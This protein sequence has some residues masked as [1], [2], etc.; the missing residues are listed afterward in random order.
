MSG[1]ILYTAG[2]ARSQKVQVHKPEASA[3]TSQCIC[4]TCQGVHS[5]L[6][7]LQQPA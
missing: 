2:C 7:M 1:I 3:S 5:L 6:Q 4:S